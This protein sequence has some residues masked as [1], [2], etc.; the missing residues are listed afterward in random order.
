V[1]PERAESRGP[2]AEHEQDEDRRGAERGDRQDTGR[3]GR[4]E[5]TAREDIIA[6]SA[7][8]MITIAQRCRAFNV[9][10]AEFCSRRTSRA[11]AAN[12]PTRR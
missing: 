1:G 7:Q 4:L 2:E 5:S 8:D 3:R 6:A 12:S 11:L 9:G 10:S